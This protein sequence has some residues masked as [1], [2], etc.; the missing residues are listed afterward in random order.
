[1]RFKEWL[2]KKLLPPSMTNSIQRDI[3]LRFFFVIF[4]F[5]LLGIAIIIKATIIMVFERPEPLIPKNIKYDFISAIYKNCSYDDLK[6]LYDRKERVIVRANRD[7][8][9]YA[10]NVD[11]AYI[12]NDIIC[13]YYLG[14]E[15]DTFFLSR[16][17]FLKEEA[18]QKYPFDKLNSTQKDLFEKVKSSAG[19]DYAKIENGIIL[20]ANELYNR[21]NDIDKYLDKSNQSYI[22]SIMAFFISLFPFIP[23]LW[24]YYKK[25][26]SKK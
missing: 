3:M 19:D 21:N 7:M 20:I 10:A 14:N 12:I 2:D 1:M 25:K 9:A 16:L 11:I 13:D 26:I 17:Y 15:V 18:R 24:K 22:L 5:M 23:P 8:N 4:L 6:R